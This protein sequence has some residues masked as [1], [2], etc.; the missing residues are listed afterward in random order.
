VKVL[1]T[2]VKSIEDTEDRFL[3]A[4]R[5]EEAGLK[6]AVSQTVHN[7]DEA[8]KTA[9]N[10]GYPLMVRIAYALGGLGSGIV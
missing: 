8:K 4:K 6:C 7:I 5:V 9:K 2:P 3:F 1:G 10:I